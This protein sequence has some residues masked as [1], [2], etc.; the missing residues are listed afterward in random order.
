MLKRVLLSFC[1]QNPVNLAP[2]GSCMCAHLF[3]MQLS[4]HRFMSSSHSVNYDRF[5]TAKR[6]SLRHYKV[7]KLWRYVLFKTIF[8]GF[9]LYCWLGKYVNVHAQ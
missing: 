9:T 8:I 4:S 7:M 2:N 1:G 3:S 5:F 6:R